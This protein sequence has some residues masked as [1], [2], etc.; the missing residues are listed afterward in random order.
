MTRMMGGADLQRLKV[1]TQIYTLQILDKNRQWHNWSTIGAGGLKVGRAEKTAQF[2]ELS[3]MATKHLRISYEGAKVK[4]EDLGS[5]NGIYRKLSQ[6]I[7]LED[8]TRFRI[9]G[10]ILEF[11]RAESVAPVVPLIGEDG[12]EFWCRDVQALAFL[13]A[14][15]PDGRPGLRFPITKRDQTVLGRENR[16]GRP[17]DIAF[18]EDEVVSGQHAQI[19]HQDGAFYLEDLNSRNGTF[20]KIEGVSL[21]EPGEELLVGRVLLRVVAQ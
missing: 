6:P 16:P 9:G 15:R 2:P 7:A 10:Q 14:I 4:V 13:D 21:V 5:L 1:P 12:E 20:V 3:S 18:P 11:R 19:R 17:V 8:G